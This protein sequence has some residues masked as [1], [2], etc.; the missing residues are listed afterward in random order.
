MTEALHDALAI[1]VGVLLALMLVAAARRWAL[2]EERVYA[3]G[4]LVAALVYGVA[5][6]AQ[7]P[8]LL[9]VEWLGVA[10]FGAIAFVGFHRRAVLAMGWALHVAWDLVIPAHHS[11]VV[12]PDWYPVL[13]VGF[14]LALAAYL[15][16][17]GRGRP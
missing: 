16:Q 8:G 12:V 6:A 11:G 2:R 5:S 1:I 17:S 4:L 3:I 13:C 14:D 15:L 10:I 7:A 9:P